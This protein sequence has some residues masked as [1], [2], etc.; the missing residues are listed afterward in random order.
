[1]TSV[2]LIGGKYRDPRWLVM[3]ELTSYILYLNIVAQCAKWM[4]TTISEQNSTTKADEENAFVDS[5]EHVAGGGTR[6][7]V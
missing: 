7:W 4:T 1:M 3:E 5:R 2:S 6:Q